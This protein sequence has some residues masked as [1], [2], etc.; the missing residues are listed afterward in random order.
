M[1]ASLNLWTH[2]F[3][4]KT[5]RISPISLK[6]CLKLETEMGRIQ[7]RINLY[8]TKKWHI[9]STQWQRIVDLSYFTLLKGLAMHKFYMIEEQLKPEL[10]YICGSRISKTVPDACTFQNHKAQISMVN[11][12]IMSLLKSFNNLLQDFSYLSSFKIF[13]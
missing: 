3:H 10:N 7:W 13:L 1:P 5:P 9:L 12:F 11:I 4:T 8:N 6:K 2:Y